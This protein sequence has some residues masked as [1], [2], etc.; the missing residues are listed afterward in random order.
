MRKFI[1]LAVLLLS[2]AVHARSLD[3]LSSGD[4][5]AG[6]KEALTQ[7]ASKAVDLLGR[8][9][10]FL[11]NPKVR[12]PLPDKLNRAGKMMRSVG[13][14]KQVDE[15]ETT[16]N[17]AAEAAVPEAKK[18]LV[19]A[20][21]G[22]SVQDAKGILAGGNNSATEYFRRTTSAPLGDKFRPIVQQAIARVKLAEQYNKFAGSAARFGL[23]S[24][25]DGSLDGYVTNKALDGLFMMMAEEEKAIRENPLRAA[26]SLAQ[27]VF[28]VLR[29]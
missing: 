11:G 17:R 23:I 21:K 28:G 10:G 25:E 3:Q 15:L 2:G 24:K 14:G 18:L 6:L 19:D 7:G 27:K 1:I 16:L 13:M 4:A 8:E 29:N 26:G 12:I 5:T 22:M 9:N 20:I